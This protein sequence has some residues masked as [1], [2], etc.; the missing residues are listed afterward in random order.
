MANKYNTTLYT[1]VTNDIKRRVAEHKLHINKGFTDKY[2]VEK[3]VFFE[4]C[5]DMTTAIRREK[6]I[7]K[8]RREWKETLIK[9][10]NPEW[11]DL[12]EDLGVNEEY[13]QLVK[14]V[15]NEMDSEVLGDCGSSPQ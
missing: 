13:L 3:L 2:Y 4:I 9:D 15:Y 12:S 8:W 5:N 6:Q 1:G 7:K 14:E 10:I 11:K